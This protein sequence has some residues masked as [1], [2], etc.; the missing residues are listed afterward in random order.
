MLNESFTLTTQ[1]V[2]EVRKSRCVTPVT[3]R[4]LQ[5]LCWKYSHSDVFLWMTKRFMT[6]EPDSWPIW[7]LTSN[8][9]DISDGKVSAP[10]NVECTWTLLYLGIQEM[11]SSQNKIP[12]LWITCTNTLQSHLGC[13]SFDNLRVMLFWIKEIDMLKCN[14]IKGIGSILFLKIG[15]KIFCRKKL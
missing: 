2:P 12:S 5:T 15:F 8:P 10:I 4:D 13:D 9:T 3:W 6:V 1:Q 11:T 14:S 7:T